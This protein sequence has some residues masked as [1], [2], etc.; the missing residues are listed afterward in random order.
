MDWYDRGWN[1]FN[2]PRQ[3]RGGNPDYP[4]YEGGGGFPTADNR[5][6]AAYPTINATVSDPPLFGPGE[7]EIFRRELLWWRDIRYSVEDSALITI[8]A[9][10]AK[11]DLLKSLLTTFMGST[12][13]HIEKQNSRGLLKLHDSKL[14]KAA[15]EAAVLKMNIWSNFSRKNGETMR[16][17]WRRYDR[18]IVSWQKS[19][20]QMPKKIAFRKILDAMKLTGSQLSIL[21][22]TLERKTNGEETL[23]ELKR[24]SAK[25]TGR[26]FV[27]E[28]GRILKIEGDGISH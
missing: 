23:A 1:D 24:L 10:R 5:N 28:C 16:Q 9:I 12:R 13:L 3:H 8:I 25:L 18:L 21:L 26:R 6:R 7:F 27:E 20:I 4:V 15:E 22:G 19:D 14:A 11:G 2:D 17:M